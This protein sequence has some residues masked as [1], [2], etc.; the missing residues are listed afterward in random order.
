M[1]HWCANRWRDIA[2]LPLVLY[3]LAA[4]LLLLLLLVVL[5]Y[6]AEPMTLVARPFRRSAVA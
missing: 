3:P 5:V 1:P 4:S 6:G 2:L